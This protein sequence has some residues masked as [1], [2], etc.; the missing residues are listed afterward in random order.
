MQAMGLNKSS[1]PIAWAITTLIEIAITF[2]LCCLVLYGGGILDTSSKWYVAFLL[3]LFGLSVL[4][5]W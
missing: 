2:F 1:D 4:S 5:F 3:L